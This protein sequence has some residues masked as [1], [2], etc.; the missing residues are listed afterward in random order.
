MWSS[1]LLPKSLTRFLDSTYNQLVQ[2][3]YVDDVG[4]G[5]LNQMISLSLADGLRGP[6]ASLLDFVISRCL[7]SVNICC[8]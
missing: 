6:F 7:L 3:I 1:E 2:I 5:G 4:A 8:K